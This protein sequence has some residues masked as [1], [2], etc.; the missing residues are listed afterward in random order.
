MFFLNP[1][2]S[3]K[4][5]R[6]FS[7]EHSGCERRKRKKWPPCACKACSTFTWEMEPGAA[8]LVYEVGHGVAG[9]GETE[10]IIAWRQNQRVKA[11]PSSLGNGRLA[12]SPFL[13]PEPPAFR[14]QWSRAVPKLSFLNSNLHQS[15]VC[16]QDPGSGHWGRQPHHGCGPSSCR[17][18]RIHAGPSGT[19]LW[20]SPAHSRW[21]LSAL[22]QR[23]VSARWPCSLGTDTPQSTMGPRL[24][25]CDLGYINHEMR[26]PPRASEKSMNS[27]LL[28]GVC[29]VS[30]DPD[31]VRERAGASERRTEPGETARGRPGLPDLHP[32]LKRPLSFTRSRGNLGDSLTAGP[33][34][35]ARRLRAPPRRM[36]APL[37]PPTPLPRP[38]SRQ[39]RG[40]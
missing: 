24:S 5:R 39:R 13:S 9:R 26:L 21:E 11:K 1:C 12:P 16:A 6:G 3:Q 32:P 25:V 15:P 4:G 33:G 10:G 38:V 28:T 19:R 23:F 29:G 30:K 14:T 8:P 22:Q 20:G 2:A 40:F 18:R 31:L 17:D 36:V 7:G 27:V 35:R 34:V 37:C